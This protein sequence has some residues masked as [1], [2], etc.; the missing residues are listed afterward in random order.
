VDNKQVSVGEAVKFG[1]KGMKSNFWL[2]FVLLVIV[3]SVE[4]FFGYIMP[5]NAEAQIDWN[6]KSWL[7]M[8]VHLFVNVFIALGFTHIS[9]R[10][11]KGERPTFAD[12]FNKTGVYFQFFGAQILYWVVVAVGLLLLVFPGIIWA[13]RYWMYPYMVVDKKAD[14][15]EALKLSSKATY[16]AKWDLLGFF[17]ASVLIYLAGFAVFGV[18]LLAALPTI[19]IGHAFWYVKLIGENSRGES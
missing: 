19:M 9:L 6:W 4:L 8:L 7:L 15:F 1:W 2:F 3:F 12:F 16:G 14:P 10:A 17:F 11:A 18:G 13:M 5:V